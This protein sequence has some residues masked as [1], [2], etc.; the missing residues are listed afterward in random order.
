MLTTSG[1]G[2]SQVG[3]EIFRA[4]P[5]VPLMVLTDHQV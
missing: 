2:L 5:A 3:E 4:I 1:G